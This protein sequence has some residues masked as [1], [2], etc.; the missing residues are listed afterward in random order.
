MTSDNVMR[1]S[2]SD[3]RS[4]VDCLWTITGPVGHF[5]TFT[6]MRLDLPTMVDC[7]DTDYLQLQEDNVTSPVLGS[8][9]GNAPQPPVDSFGNSVRLLFHS[10]SNQQ[11][12]SGFLIRVNASIEGEMEIMIF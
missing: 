1:A 12:K 8:Y 4:N 5:L 11:D 6:F 10:D 2:L 7:L 3:V 9:C